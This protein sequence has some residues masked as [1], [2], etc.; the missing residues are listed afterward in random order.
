MLKSSSIALLT[1]VVLLS[2]PGCTTRR[3][4]AGSELTRAIESLDTAIT[5]LERE[6]GRV[7]E[8]VRGT[9]AD[10]RGALHEI[11]RAARGIEDHVTPDVVHD[12]D[13]LAEGANQLR[14]VCRA[15]RPDQLGLVT[16]QI[17]ARIQ[18]TSDNLR[19]VRQAVRAALPLAAAGTDRRVG[20]LATASSVSTVRVS[21][22]LYCLL[23]CVGLLSSIAA[24]RLPAGPARR[25]NKPLF[26]ALAALGVL[27]MTVWA[28]PIATLATRREISIADGDKVCR[29]SAD[30]GA[31]LE[32]SLRGVVAARA[33]GAYTLA[34]ASVSDDELLKL[35]D[36]SRRKIFFQAN[37]AE[38]ET[39]HAAWETARRPR[40]FEAL[41]SQV[42]ELSAQC[43]AFAA[44][45]DAAEEARY[46]LALST[47]YL[48]QHDPC[49]DR[50]GC[51][52]SDRR[53]A[54]R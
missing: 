12:I 25:Y 50:L 32:S 15:G 23:A 5:G 11:Q 37:R 26:G 13:G 29:E 54:Q 38:A 7:S 30:K 16:W 46:H 14:R 35:V 52:V 42:R 34:S 22:A 6:R 41:A 47:G 39:A 4:A 8:D 19:A 3:I 18:A 28:R 49:A 40:E 17:A 20:K 44:T 45:R 36:G 48:E 43:V 33:G 53:R 21:G 51:D 10:L 24:V 27:T 1:C 9:V 2:L 31:A